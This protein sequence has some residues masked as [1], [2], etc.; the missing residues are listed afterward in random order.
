MVCGGD[1]LAVTPTTTGVMFTPL[2]VLSM[3]RCLAWRETRSLPV[4]TPTGPRET[5][6]HEVL[7]FPI[8]R[9]LPASHSPSVQNEAC[10]RHA[11]S[12]VLGFSANSPSAGFELYPGC[13]QGRGAGDGDMAA[14]A[15][16]RERNAPVGRRQA[17]PAPGLG[18]AGLGDLAA[19]ILP[20]CGSC[21]SQSLVPRGL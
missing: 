7:P 1:D 4:G 6:G 12:G 3:C 14:A 18:L 21:C 2:R 17:V 13:C 11:C 9:I 16:R 15:D 10:E 20:V 8:E 19:P 5:C